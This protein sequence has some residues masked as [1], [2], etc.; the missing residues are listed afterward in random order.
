MDLPQAPI[1]QCVFKGR[2]IKR[3]HDGGPSSAVLAAGQ[4]TPAARAAGYPTPAALAAGDPTPAALA[5]EGPTLA[6]GSSSMRPKFSSDKNH[7]NEFHYKL[8]LVP[9]E[10]RT[11][12]QV[13]RS[14][15]ATCPDIF[16]AFVND[17]IAYEVNERTSRKRVIKEVAEMYF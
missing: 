6:R 5:A 16:D 4:P 2:P 11:Q 1:V 13:I 8:K 14:Q 15:E 17:V 7:Y 10:M 9:A 3:E 12:W